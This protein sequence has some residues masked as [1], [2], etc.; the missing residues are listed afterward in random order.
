MLNL[1]RAVA[2]RGRI[3]VRH[4]SSFPSADGQCPHPDDAARHDDP[5]QHAAGNALSFYWFRAESCPESSETSHPSAPA[6][7]SRTLWRA[8]PDPSSHTIEMSIPPS[9]PSIIAQRALP[10]RTRTT[11]PRARAKC[12]PHIPD[13]PAGDPADAPP[14]STPPGSKR[15]QPITQPKRDQRTEPLRIGPD[16]PVDVPRSIRQRVPQLRCGQIKIA[17]RKL[18]AAHRNA[19]P[20]P[21]RLIRTPL[22]LHVSW[23]PNKTSGGRHGMKRC[24]DQRRRV[25]GSGDHDH[26][27]RLS[28]STAPRPTS[29]KAA[30][31]ISN[32]V[33]T[34]S[35]P[36][37]TSSRS[38]TD[39]PAT[40]ARNTCSA[41]RA[42]NLGQIVPRTVRPRNRH[43]PQ[44]RQSRH[45]RRP[46]RSDVPRRR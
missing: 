39:T 11:D 19:P 25:H 3:L 27:D 14:P 32:A 23:G 18:H 10:R 26:D 37:N 41:G 15:L 44:I 35:P 42:S 4:V 46:R 8:I 30:R 13:T 29:A 40:G 20:A 22:R 33:N 24:V 31:S 1:A 34:R 5:P 43:H 38:S 2:L 9:R 16:Q 21:V 6:R 12:R 17:G 36:R 7:S 45:R 28:E